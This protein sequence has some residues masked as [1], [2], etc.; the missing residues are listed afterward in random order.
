M[1]TNPDEIRELFVV[2]V[3]YRAY[4]FADDASD[5]RE[6]VDEI[7]TTEEP[8]DVEILRATGK[9]LGWPGQSLV[10]TDGEECNLHDAMQTMKDR[11]SN[12]TAQ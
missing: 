9:E 12:K 4:V 1:N 10:Y 6:F 2:T 3:T 8:D 5:A 11:S 7:V